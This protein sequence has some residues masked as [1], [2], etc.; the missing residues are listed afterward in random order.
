MWKQGT[1][2][3]DNK[4]STPA[5]LH[6][7]AGSNPIPE[8]IP[9]IDPSESF[10]TLGIYLSL[11][12]SQ[13]RQVSILRSHTESHRTLT[14]PLACTSLTQQQCKYSPGGLVTKDAPQ[15]AFPPCCDLR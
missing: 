4:A 12:G 11:S 6:L 3:S 13:S 10:R 5:N 9:R 7:T 2:K 14:Y 15:P 8:T 1:P